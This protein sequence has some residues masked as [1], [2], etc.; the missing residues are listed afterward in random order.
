MRLAS[1]APSGSLEYYLYGAP[2]LVE[3]NVDTVNVCNRSATDSLFRISINS[4]I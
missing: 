4:A 2:E 3:V 1:V